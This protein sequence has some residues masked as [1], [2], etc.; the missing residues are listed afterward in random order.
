MKKFIISLTFIL[1]FCINSSAQDI[2][3]KSQLQDYASEMSDALIE[4][5][6]N[7]NTE[8]SAKVEALCESFG[9]LIGELMISNTELFGEALLIFKEM[10]TLELNKRDVPTEDALAISKEFINSLLGEISNMLTE[11]NNYLDN[12]SKEL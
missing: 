3:I 2:N 4:A 11:L 9:E 5:L 7:N 10:F 8:N 1:A 12:I 6:E